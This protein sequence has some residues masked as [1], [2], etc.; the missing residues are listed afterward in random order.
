VNIPPI[1]LCAFEECKEAK[2]RWRG[3]LCA[4]NELMEV[5]DIFSTMFN[6]ASHSNER[7]KSQNNHY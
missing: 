7:D 1:M 6:H 5:R 4:E 3:L 2:F